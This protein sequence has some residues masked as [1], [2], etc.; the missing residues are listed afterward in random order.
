MW[1]ELPPTATAPSKPAKLGYHGCA[2]RSPDGRVWRGEGGIVS[3][4][5]ARSPQAHRDDGRVWER[6]L[7]ETAPDGALPLDWGLHGF[8]G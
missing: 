6:R 1:S 8:A 4:A 2:L 3:M 5:G 7:L